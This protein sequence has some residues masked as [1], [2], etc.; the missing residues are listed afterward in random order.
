[1][2]GTPEEA[3]PP[4]TCAPLTPRYTRGSQRRAALLASAAQ[5]PHDGIDSMEIQHEAVLL[6]SISTAAG[7]TMVHL[8]QTGIIASLLPGGATPAPDY[9]PAYFMQT[10]PCVFPH[11]AGARPTGMDQKVYIRTLLQRYPEAQ[12]AGNRSFL[13]NAFDSMQRHK[14]SKEA[15]YLLYTNPDMARGLDGITEQEV[16]AALNTVGLSGQALYSNMDALTPKS[17]RLL[18]ALKL[19]GARVMGSP[20]SKM[21]ARSKT[22]AGT[23]VFGTSTVMV[24]L[25]TSELSAQCTFEMGGRGYKFDLS[26][27]AV[28]RMP[29]HEAR[30]YVATHPFACATFFDIYYRAVNEVIIGWK[31]G[32]PEQTNPDCLCG[33]VHYVTASIEESGRGGQHAHMTLVQ[34]QLQARTLEIM[35]RDNNEDVRR[36]LLLFGERLACACWPTVPSSVRCE[37]L[38]GHVHV[39]G[40][41]TARVWCLKVTSPPLRSPA[42]HLCVGRE[43]R[44]PLSNT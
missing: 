20:Q 6:P 44:R 4:P 2:A 10:H 34:P 36:R 25:C 13:V 23:T 43:R 38:R 31:L 37:R 11:G 12:F 3:T 21:A 5:P 19:V 39:L 16:A 1:M 17:R 33:I 27:M 18:L 40:T 29:V 8:T 35:L 28:G 22:M 26:G 42:Q 41:A 14:V 32:E 15:G 30:Q 9:D 7:N 24:N